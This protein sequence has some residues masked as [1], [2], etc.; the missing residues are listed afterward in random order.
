MTLLD[1]SKYRYGTIEYIISFVIVVVIYAEYLLRINPNGD[2]NDNIANATY[3]SLLYMSFI[4]YNRKVFL[5]NLMMLMA[6][7]LYTIQ[8]PDESFDGLVLGYGLAVLITYYQL[9]RRLGMRKLRLV[10]DYSPFD[11]IIDWIDNAVECDRRPFKVDKLFTCLIYGFSLVIIIRGMQTLNTIGDFG[12]TSEVFVKSLVVNAPLI[13]C[14]LT[15]ISSYEVTIMRIIY[16]LSEMY[17][18]IMMYLETKNIEMMFM[19]S[20][21]IF[22]VFAAISS[23][24]G[25][26]ADDI[27]NGDAFRVDYNLKNY[28][29]EEYSEHSKFYDIDPIEIDDTEEK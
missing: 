1:N 29:P 20:L 14:M 27:E 12:D 28:F 8:I 9:S 7:L 2:M 15:V 17:L 25:A 11:K 6:L 24:E 23:I 5:S 22:L 16:C 21:D 13:I 18:Y 3:V 19:A 26:R 10:N 4:L